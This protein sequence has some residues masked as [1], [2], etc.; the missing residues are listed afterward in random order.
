MDR[1]IPKE[2]RQR[3]RRKQWIKIGAGV[4]AAVVVMGFI[5]AS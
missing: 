4:V 3:E 2:V 5:L 1:E